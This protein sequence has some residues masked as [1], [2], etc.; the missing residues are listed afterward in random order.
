M[1]GVNHIVVTLAGAGLFCVFAIP[2][3]D[4]AQR[5][6]PSRDA[7]HSLARPARALLCMISTGNMEWLWFIS[8]DEAAE[9]CGHDMNRIRNE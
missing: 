1:H 9:T 3:R 7:R 8:P 6:V 2:V 5:L 4:S